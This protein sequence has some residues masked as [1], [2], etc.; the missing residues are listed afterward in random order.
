MGR[1]VVTER[2]IVAK[3]FSLAC[4]VLL[5]L[6]V[7]LGAA[8][9]GQPTVLDP[10]FEVE[11]YA[12][13][14][15]SCLKMA[16]DDDANLYVLQRGEGKILKVTPDGTAT[17]FFGSAPRVGAD[18]LR[19]MVWTGGTAYGDHLF[20]VR[21]HP[22]YNDEILR[23]DPNGVGSVLA[24]MRPPR[25]RPSFVD[26]DRSGGYG[27]HLYTGTTGQDHLYRVMTDGTVA[28]FSPW[29]DWVNDGGPY[30]M[31]F[32]ASGLYGGMGFVGS[33][34]RENQ[35]AYSGLFQVGSS[36]NVTRFTSELASA[37]Y[38]R[39]D[40]VGT[41]FGHGLF[42]DGWPRYG[43]DWQEAGIY[44]VYPDATTEIF[45][46][47]D[48]AWI[49]WAFT[50]GNDGAMY[51]AERLHVPALETTIY[52]VFLPTGEDPV[53]LCSNVTVAAGPDCT[54][55]A[56]VDAG[57]FDPQGLA[58]TLVQEPP[59]PY[60]LGVTE[61]VLT[62]D[63]GSA[64]ATCQAAVTVVDQAAPFVS[65]NAP[66]S[67]SPWEVPISFTATGTDNCGLRRVLVR[68]PTCHWDWGEDHSQFSSQD[69][70]HVAA[71]DDTMTI[72]NPGRSNQIR[73]LA[74]AT[75][76]SGNRIVRRCS[77]DM[78]SGLPPAGWQ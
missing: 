14:P 46:Q 27:G 71:Q 43:S 30:S 29:P 37:A 42:A 59:G 72:L 73:W 19:D 65:C 60:G 63:N 64:E 5:V 45:I 21:L 41:M 75:D 16:F 40:P 70:C 35:A 61:V 38:I 32:D 54:A 11:E 69:L 47:R 34:F 44:R 24:E 78:V 66:P 4:G 23:I 51:V 36:G 74:R 52:R 39:F 10:A 26:I 48:P 18:G 17:E 9:A 6:I 12:T 77:V 2:R 76:T 7:A 25:H 50:F 13:V 20:V 56:S 33:W 62:A 68:K 22:D 55:D 67:I 28:L 8:A 58:I 53:A 3:P 57:S 15:G 1:V 31:D 49:Q